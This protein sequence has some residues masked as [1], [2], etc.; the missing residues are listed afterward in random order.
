MA[1]ITVASTASLD[2]V[3]AMHASFI[4]ALEAG[5]ALTVAAP[6]YIAS[7][8]KVYKSVSTQTTISG[9]S[10]YI[11]FTP[12]SVVSGGPVT[13]FR[14]GTRFNF[15]TG[16]TPNTPLYVSTTAGIL[17]TVKQAAN[18]APVAI[19]VSATDILVIK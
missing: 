7:D 6:C 4:S 3:S 17:N 10:D 11:G 18:D 13:L 16:M 8:G 9:Y 14:S 12:D 1:E 19:A 2:A 5:E 15:S